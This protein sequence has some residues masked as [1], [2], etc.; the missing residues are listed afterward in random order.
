M[1][2]LLLVDLIPDTDTLLQMS[3]SNIEIDL[4]FYI[5]VH[6]QKKVLW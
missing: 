5:F 6:L 4:V 3:V 1:A 2:K